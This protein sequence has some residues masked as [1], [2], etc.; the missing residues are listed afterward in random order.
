MIRDIIVGYWYLTLRKLNLLELSL[1]I[2]ADRRRAVCDA[3]PIRKSLMGVRYCGGCGCVLA[4]KELSDSD[5][6]N[7]FWELTGRDYFVLANTEGELIENNEGIVKFDKLKDAR[8]YTATY[9]LEVS[10]LY[11]RL[12]PQ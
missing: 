8:A 5:C 9:N 3:C 12:K 4:A 1:V 2:I 11:T 10:Y 6:P 7:G